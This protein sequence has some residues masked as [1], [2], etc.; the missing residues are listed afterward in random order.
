MATRKRCNPNR[1]V[2]SGS[3][4]LG[5]NHGT[6]VRMPKIERK[7][8]ISNAWISVAMGRTKPWAMENPILAAS[9]H[10]MPRKLRLIT[11]AKSGDFSDNAAIRLTSRSPT[12]YG[13][14][15]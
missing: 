5:R 4:P 6:T 9:E 10:P 1:F 8:T 7:K 15:V 14:R 13:D 11:G 3:R 12:I 2:R